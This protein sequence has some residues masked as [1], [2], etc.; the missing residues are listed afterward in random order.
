MAAS[1]IS[2]EAKTKIAKALHPEYAP[3]KVERDDACKA[4]TQFIS[5]QRAA[6]AGHK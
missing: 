3:T 1:H 5:G 6:K 2:F 4:F